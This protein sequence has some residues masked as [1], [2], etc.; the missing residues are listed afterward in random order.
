MAVPD[1][2]FNMIH[3]VNQKSLEIIDIKKNKMWNTQHGKNVTTPYD[4]R[5]NTNLIKIGRNYVT[6]THTI[7]NRINYV[8][9]FLVVG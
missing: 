7:P 4:L 3:K 8:S 5:G 6:L 9:Y 2:P 1:K